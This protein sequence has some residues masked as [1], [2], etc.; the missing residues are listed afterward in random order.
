M[1]TA[2]KNLLLLWIIHV[3]SITSA[4]NVEEDGES[5]PTMPVERIDSNELNIDGRLDAPRTKKICRHLF[6]FQI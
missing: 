1:K 4:V 6:S 5:N 2:A 3:Y